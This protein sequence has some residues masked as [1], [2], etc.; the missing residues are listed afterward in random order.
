MFHTTLHDE[1]TNALRMG[2]TE[3]E[4]AQLVRSSFTQAFDSQT[5]KHAHQ[6]AR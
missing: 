5:Q 4:L 6:T 1:Y 3:S 2:L